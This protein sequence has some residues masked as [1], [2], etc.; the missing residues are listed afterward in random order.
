MSGW[1]DKVRK[2]LRDRSVVTGIAA[3]AGEWMENHIQAN[4]GRGPGGNP[5]PHLPL[6]RVA[7][8]SWTTTRPRDGK[9]LFSQR[10]TVIVNGKPQLRT[11]YRVEH[12]S[13]RAGGQPLRDTGKLAGSLSA[14]GQFTG[15][16]IVLTMR[17]RKYG[18][19]Q[20]RGFRTKGPNYIPIS[21]K[22]RRG[23]G[24]GNNP[25]AEGLKRGK[26][27]IMRWKGVTVPARPFIL[28]TRDDMRTLGKSIY[29]GLRSILKG[30]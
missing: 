3:V 14:T 18:L 23:H 6:K 24:T 2:A 19:Y 27:F 13:Y 7:G 10:R 22:G 29:L 15:G 21:L 8:R 16:K 9:F 20:D 1:I 28:P 4:E 12:V 17:G 11:F 25:N 26:D 5:Q 30:K